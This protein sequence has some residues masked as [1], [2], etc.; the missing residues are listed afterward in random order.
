MEILIYYPLEDAQVESFRELA[1]KYGSHQ[2][3]QVKTEEEAIRHAPECE[4]IF[5]HFPRSVFMAAPKLRWVQ[6]FSAGM[7]KFLFPEAIESDVMVSNAAGIHAIQGGEHAWAMLLSLARGIVA[8]VDSQREHVWKGGTAP[9]EVTGGTLGVIGLG[10]FGME[11][12][13]RARGYEMTVIGLDP[14]RTERPDGVDQMKTPTR[15]SILDLLRRSDAVMVAC[16]HTAETHHM[17]DAEALRAMKPT[18]YLVNVTR[19]GIVDEAALQEALEKGEI[20]GAGLDVCEQE[21]LPPE[22]PLWD[23]PNLVITPH[24]AGASQHRPK[25]LYTF[26]LE[27]LERY[28]KGEKPLNVVDKRKGY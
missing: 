23:A 15:E 16:P 14:V 17:I 19:G 4:V 24:R 13:K 8:G 3:H 28:L 10:G 7:D 6:S 26:F 25:R 12:V 2:V 1:A 21:P 9:V 18:A 11:M 27:N 5:G 20:A 22:S